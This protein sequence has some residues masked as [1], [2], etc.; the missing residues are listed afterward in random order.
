ME[1]YDYLGTSDKEIFDDAPQDETQLLG[2]VEGSVVGHCDH[3]HKSLGT[4]G[5][6]CYHTHSGLSLPSGLGSIS[7]PGIN[8]S[9]AAECFRA[10]NSPNSLC[11]VS[12]YSSIS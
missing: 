2:L 6:W 7:H 9:T 12:R 8:P 11:L 3:C 10:F 1:T 4:S 5:S